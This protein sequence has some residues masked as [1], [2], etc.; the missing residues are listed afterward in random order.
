MSNEDWYAP[1]KTI[2]LTGAG[3][4]KTFGGYLA[5]EMWAEIFNQP[6]IQSEPKLRESLLF[7]DNLNYEAVYNQVLES[8]DYSPNQ[9]RAITAAIRRAYEGMDKAIQGSI[10]DY[11]SAC[12]YFIRLFADAE[13]PKTRGYVFTLNQDLF[14]E[15]F[16]SIPDDYRSVI[17]I[18][19]LS[20]PLWFKFS[21]EPAVRFEGVQLP[22]AETVAHYKEL[23][24]TEGSGQFMYIKLHGSYGWLSKDGSEAMVIG[25]GKT[26]RIEKEP[27]LKWFLSIFE[28]VL[29]AGNRNL[30]VIGYGFGDHHINAILIDAIKDSGLRLHVV[31]PMEPEA[32]KAHV[33][34]LHG[35]KIKQY[36]YG[37]EIWNGLCGY[38]QNKVTDFYDGHSPSIWPAR[39]E[40]FIQNLGLR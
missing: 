31:C 18:P 40:E 23:L 33:K 37:H 29:H 30:V 12:R 36:Y 6:E 32:F 10:E 27:L 4:T 24:R 1:A 22:D 19:S 26:G 7:T 2:L 14:L 15:R 25:E 35:D 17:R 20:H 38:Y 16:Y 9:K 34:E 13:N 11:R 39:G 8:T 5:S 28:E 3:F 21:A